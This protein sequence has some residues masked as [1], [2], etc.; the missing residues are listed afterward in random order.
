MLYP[1]FL[2]GYILEDP[3]PMSGI[4]QYGRILHDRVIGIKLINDGRHLADVKWLQAIM[5]M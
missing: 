5:T 1:E 3:T 4:S 2:A